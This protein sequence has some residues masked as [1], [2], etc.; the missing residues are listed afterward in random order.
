MAQ[1]RLNRCFG[2][3]WKLFGIRKMPEASTDVNVGER[4][5]EVVPEKKVRRRRGMWRLTSTRFQGWRERSS[6][7]KIRSCAFGA[8]LD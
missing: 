3:G 7:T 1:R 6:S 2:E 4:L 8:Q 5:R